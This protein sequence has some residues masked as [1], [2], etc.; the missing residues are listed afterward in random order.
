MT[1]KQRHKADM[2]AA[3]IV[4]IAAAL[5]HE[6]WRKTHV[7][8]R[9]SVPRWKGI[10]PA[11]YEQWHKALSEEEHKTMVKIITNDKNI[12]E[13]YE[14]DI[15]SNFKLLPPSKREEN[16]RAVKECLQL[17]AVKI[18]VHYFNEST[19]FSF[20]GPEVHEQWLSRQR[21]ENSGALPRWVT[22]CD[23]H[24]PFEELPEDEQAKDLDLVKICLKCFKPHEYSDKKIDELYGKIVPKR[25]RMFETVMTSAVSPVKGMKRVASTLFFPCSPGSEAI[26]GKG[27]GDD[28][29][30]GVLA[31]D[32]V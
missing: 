3:G 23:L 7:K 30:V 6:Q 12:G 10:S 27:P 26:H 24:L 28:V 5:M 16:E 25:K 17:L 11:E 21:E 31:Q 19:Y 22:D 18:T 1:A 29:E 20:Y 8:Q 15:N 9:G 32:K 4:E 13:E 14:V 2:E